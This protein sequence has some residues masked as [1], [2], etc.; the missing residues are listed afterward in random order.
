MQRL[1]CRRNARSK[2]GLPTCMHYFTFLLGHPMT[3]SFCNPCKRWYDLIVSFSPMNDFSDWL[4]S[5]STWNAQDCSDC[6]VFESNFTNLRVKLIRNIFQIGAPKIVNVSMCLVV[7][8][9]TMSALCVS[10]VSPPDHLYVIYY[11][12]IQL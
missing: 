1:W 3:A 11:S 12:F 9:G 8:E 5:F 4:L 7:C 2:K 6:A 10:F